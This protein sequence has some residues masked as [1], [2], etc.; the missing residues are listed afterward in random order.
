[1]V[2]VGILNDNLI[3]AFIAGLLPVLML[4]LFLSM[5]R[6]NWALMV[7][8]TLNY[9]IPVTYH[10]V[11]GIKLGAVL[12]LLIIF[13]I[14]V[15]VVNLL[16]RRTT[17]KRVSW[18]VV[19]VAGLWVFYCF[20]EVFNPRMIDLDA[21]LLGIRSMALYLFSILIIVQISLESFEDVKSI[22]R[23]W[24]VLSLVA[25]VK[26][27]TQKFIGFTPGDLYFLNNE[28]GSVTHLIFFGIRYFSIFTDAANFGGAMG[29]SLTVFLII[30]L[31]SKK[32]A[33]KIYYWIV[34]GLSC[35]GMFL[36]GTRSALVVPVAG[37]LLYLLLSRD[38][39]KM[40]PTALLL[41][42]IVGMLA[43]TT[44]GESNAY[45]RRARTIFHHEED[46]S[47][48]GRKL[49]QAKLREIMKELP[50]GNSL[51]MSGARG[52]AYGDTSEIIQIATDSQFVQVWVETGAIGLGIFLFVFVYIMVKGAWLVMFRIKDPEIKGVAAGVLSG[53]AGLFVMCSNNEVLTQVPNGIITYMSLAIVI[54]CS[55]FDAELR[56]QQATLPKTEEL[57]DEQ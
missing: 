23:L 2:I 27:L 53:T 34:A 35:Y 46:L 25:A 47:Y 49:N 10:Y 28:G 32:K 21:W 24:S 1:M 7:L 52:K 14:M 38:F 18:D 56:E 33:E 41:G 54:L 36:S 37:I 44:V 26:S 57:P 50:F 29:V 43:F 51:K 45:I 16:T 39:K 3:L 40:V 30:G 19:A 4:V 20:L 42:V 55:K 5:E 6:K 9:L 17:V 15:L 12:D 48:V 13:N 22:I 8:F 11:H 31:H